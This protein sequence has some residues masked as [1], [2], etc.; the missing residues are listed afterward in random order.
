M[1]VIGHSNGKSLDN[2]INKPTYHEHRVISS[3]LQAGTN[4][5]SCNA[6]VEAHTYLMSMLQ[7]P[8]D[9]E[10]LHLGW[11]YP[12]R[13][14]QILL[15]TSSTKYPSLVD[16][17]LSMCSISIITK[18]WHFSIITDMTDNLTFAFPNYPFVF[19]LFKAFSL[20]NLNVILCIL[21]S[22]YFFSFLHSSCA[23]QTVKYSN[24]C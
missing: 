2:Y 16:H 13:N 23:L 5:V 9:L 21:F 19:V 15:I 17:S 1:L 24:N 14:C 8:S 4:P 22:C 7:D 3:A 20:T 11:A 18:Y 12:E 10:L 6:S